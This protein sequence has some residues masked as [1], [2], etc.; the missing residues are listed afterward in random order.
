MPPR[1][2]P[3][4]APAAPPRRRFLLSGL[5]A[6][7][8]AGSGAA[9]RPGRA[10]SAAGVCAFGVFPYL[11]ALRIEALM[12]PV[13]LELGRALGT[14]V[15]LKSKET[16]EAFQGELL[17]GRYD[18]ALVHPFFFVEASARQGYRALARIDEEL[19]AVLLA[20]DPAPLAGLALLRGRTVALPPRLAAVSYLMAAELIDAGLRPG[21]DLELRYFPDKVSCLHAVATGAAAACALPSFVLSQLPAAEMRAHPVWRSRPVPNLVVATHPRLPEAGRAALLGRMLGWPGTDAGREVL[22]RLAWPG[23]TPAGDA[24]YDPIRA[25]AAKLSA[26]AAG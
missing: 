18:I 7:G 21:A 5:A 23:L 3:G 10:A 19:R 25:L 17:A 12:G 22:A 4:P 16:F 26:R 9:P 14:D 6:A 15:Q 20:R 2:C 1:P 8:L 11:P 13:A 24:D